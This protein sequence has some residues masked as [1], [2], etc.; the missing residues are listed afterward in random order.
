MDKRAS[1]THK[2]ENATSI[3]RVGQEI[4]KR[5]DLVANVADNQELRLNQI[6][7]PF[8]VMLK[9]GTTI[10]CQATFYGSLDLTTRRGDFFLEIDQVIKSNTNFLSIAERSFHLSLDGD[11]LVSHSA[12]EVE[13]AFKNL[14]IGKALLELDKALLTPIAIKLRSSLDFKVLEIVIKDTT[15][16]SSLNWTTFRILEMKRRGED[17]KVL[18]FDIYS[19]TIPMPEA[20][21][22]TTSHDTGHTPS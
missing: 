11:K 3:F 4:V 5:L 19:L 7:I 14:G 13:E 18:D 10:S 12:L 6:Q 1:G 20:S 8:Q 22:D 17:W 9:N 15:S 2:V 21:S 16:G